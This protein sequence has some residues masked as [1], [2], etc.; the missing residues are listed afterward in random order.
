MLSLLSVKLLKKENT[1]VFEVAKIR[2]FSPPSVIGN[3]K[4]QTITKSKVFGKK[5]LKRRS[6]NLRKNI[7]FLPL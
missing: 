5:I 3:L 6:F 7:F 2:I 4:K 1:R